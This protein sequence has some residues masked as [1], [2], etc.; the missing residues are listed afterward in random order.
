MCDAQQGAAYGAGHQNTEKYS[1]AK[2]EPPFEKTVFVP[3]IECSKRVFIG[4]GMIDGNDVGSVFLG[5]GEF[6]FF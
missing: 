5:K 1:A 4:Y 2:R 3:A 6:Y